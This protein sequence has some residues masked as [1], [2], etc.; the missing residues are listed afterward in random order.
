M[1]A[2]LKSSLSVFQQK[3]VHHALSLLYHCCTAAYVG[4]GDDCNV[5]TDTTHEEICSNNVSC[6]LGAALLLAAQTCPIQ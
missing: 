4:T 1:R 6:R 5:A 2:G 3:G